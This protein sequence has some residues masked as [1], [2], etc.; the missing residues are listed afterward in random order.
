VL[1]ELNLSECREIDRA[2]LDVELELLTDQVSVVLAPV[3]PSTEPA[4]DRRHS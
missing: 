4:T 1:R 2:L 3:V